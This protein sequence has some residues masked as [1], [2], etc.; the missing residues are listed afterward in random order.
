MLNLLLQKT[1]QNIIVLF[2]PGVHESL[3]NFVYNLIIF[4][5]DNKK[6]F[7]KFIFTTEKTQN[8]SFSLI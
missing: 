3:K 6:K 1:Y 4:S 5:T 7:S 2:M 8:L